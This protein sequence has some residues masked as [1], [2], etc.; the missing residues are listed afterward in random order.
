MFKTL[1]KS[2][3]SV[4]LT[5][6][7][8]CKKIPRFFCQ[9][10]AEKCRT[11]INHR[12]KSCIRRHVGEECVRIWHLCWP[13][14]ANRVYQCKSCAN[15]YLD[16]SAFKTGNIGVLHTLSVSTSTPFPTKPYIVPLTPSFASISIIFRPHL[17]WDVRYHFLQQ[18]TFTSFC[19]SLLCCLNC[20]VCQ[21]HNCLRF[22]QC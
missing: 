10:N 16:L 14:L 3:V 12:K 4:L 18:I 7:C 13:I 19:F 17:V 2:D 15:L 21:C 6:I 22:C 20:L 8:E 11:Q 1:G 5:S 9:R